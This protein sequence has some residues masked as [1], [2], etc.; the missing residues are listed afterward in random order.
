MVELVII[1]K[2]LAFASPFSKAK[3]AI[4]ISAIDVGCYLAI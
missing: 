2:I 1:Y 4:Y 3:G